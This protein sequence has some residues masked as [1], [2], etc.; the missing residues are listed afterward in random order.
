[1]GAVLERPPLRFCGTAAAAHGRDASRDGCHP[2]LPC[3]L[4]LHCI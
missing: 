3:C 2:R 1:V 4:R